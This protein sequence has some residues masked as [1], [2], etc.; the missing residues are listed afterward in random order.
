MIGHLDY[1]SHHWRSVCYDDQHPGGL[2][3][4]QKTLSLSAPGS[5]A[6]LIEFNL[7]FSHSIPCLIPV[8]FHCLCNV[9]CLGLCYV[10]WNDH[11]HQQIC[12]KMICFGVIQSELWLVNQSFKQC[13]DSTNSMKIVSGK[14]VY[15]L[16]DTASRDT[17]MDLSVSNPY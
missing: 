16:L 5:N 13:K 11:R 7:S 1:Y 10:T 4:Y 2:H 17:Y 8:F 14:G 15:G 9:K 6:D 3:H 12:R